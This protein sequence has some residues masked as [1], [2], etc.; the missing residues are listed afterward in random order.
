MSGTTHRPALRNRTDAD[1]ATPA[2][3][4][5]AEN[6]V[7]PDDRDPEPTDVAAGH[8]RPPYAKSLAVALAAAAAVAGILIAFSWPTLTAEP[9][10]VRLA[11]TGQPQLVQ[12][13]GGAL[14]R[15]A[16][17]GL[18]L[19]VVVDRDAAISQI[20][21]REVVGALILEPRAPEVLIASAAGTGPTQLM[22]RLSDDLRA[23]LTQQ[24]TAAHQPPPKLTITDLVP[25]AAD[26]SSGTRLMIAALPLVIGGVLGGALLSIALTGRGQQLVGL[27]GFAVAGGFGLAAILHYWYGALPG[28]YPV[29]A[30]VI[31]LALLAMASVVIGLRRLLGRAGIG[32]AAALFIL[33]GNPI[34]GASVPRE[35]LPEPWGAVGQAMPQG[36]A[37]NLLR[38]LAYFPDAAIG[39]GW[40]VLG[41]WASAGLL[42]IMIAGR[43]QRAA[44]PTATDS[45][46]TS[47]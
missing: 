39:T 18:D 36:A 42:L 10:D 40:L 23:R 9:R 11:I 32:V 38:D 14:S 37:A 22:N 5:T 7:D 16:D 15:Q 6:V 43:P 24:A 26:D 30:S 34:S 12:Q 4:P 20:R 8:R 27:G 17:G 41:C 28:D 46:A 33:G 2:A 35:F 19:Q 29:F 25:Y 1:P 13:V 21:Q 44:M 3:T 31:A 45:T 47:R